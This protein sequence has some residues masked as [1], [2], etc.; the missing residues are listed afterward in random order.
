MTYEEITLPSDFVPPADAF[1]M[2]RGKRHINHEGNQRLRDLVKSELPA[3]LAAPTKTA[4]SAIIHRVLMTTRE[5]SADGIGFVRHD[6]QKGTWHLVDNGTA[7]ITVAQNFRDALSK[8]YKSSKQYKKKRRQDRK[9]NSLPGTGCKRTNKK[10]RNETT[11]ESKTLRLLNATLEDVRRSVSPTFDPPCSVPSSTDTCAGNPT[12]IL[13]GCH[14]SFSIRRFIE[15]D[16]EENLFDSLF[17]AFG[18]SQYVDPF[19]PTPVK[20]QRYQDTTFVEDKSRQSL[21][22][23]LKGWGD[24]L[25]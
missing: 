6:N 16:R 10:A 5:N 15:Q 2:G 18:T 20:E 3:Y 13:V 8:H 9:A 17:N 19:E 14:A 22:E 12:N 4:K 23:L 21:V 7:R 24:S 25:L 1:V 11:N